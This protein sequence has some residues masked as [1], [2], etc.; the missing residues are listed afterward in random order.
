MT[1]EL[2][3]QIEQRTEAWYEA[4]LGLATASHF[5]DITAITKSGQPAAARKNYRAQLMVERLTG[6]QAE[7]FTTGAMEWG[8]ETEELATTMYMLRTGNVV[9]KVGFARHPFLMAGASP[10][11]QATDKKL[12]Q[13]GGIE[14]KCYNT[15]NH[16]LALRSGHMPVEHTAQV[17][18]QNWIWKFPWVD[19][20]SFEPTLPENAQLFIERIYR[21][22]AYIEKLE[23]DVALFL[24]EVDEDVEF[25]KNYGVPV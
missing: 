16:V 24:D 4:R 3:A 9:E 2:L 6:Q 19:F 23:V 14:I 25:V 13:V 11:G 1:P 8:Q 20:I 15:A 5:K 21:D 18:G 22:E 17:Q 10:D 7:R 12:G